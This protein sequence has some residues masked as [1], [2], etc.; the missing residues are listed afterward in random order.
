MRFLQT[1][2]ARLLCQQEIN[3]YKKK[4][5]YYI[6]FARK[7]QGKDLKAN[8]KQDLKND[9][10]CEIILLDRAECCQRFG[11]EDDTDNIKMMKAILAKVE[12]NSVVV[13]DETPLS[14][15]SETKRYSWRR[16]ENTRVDDDVFVIV[17]LQPIL[18]SSTDTMLSKECQIEGPASADVIELTNQYR[19]SKK[20][21]NLYN[22]LYGLPMEFAKVDCRPSHE[23]E[24]PDI[25][26]VH[27]TE[28]THMEELRTWMDHQID[29]LDCGTENLKVIYAEE[30]E[31]LLS[32]VFEDSKWENSFVTIDEF[33]GCETHSS[34][35]P[36]PPKIERAPQK[37]ASSENA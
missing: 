20:L 30:S 34:H 14:S 10:N 35:K 2:V 7:R 26:L 12:N 15:N 4:R 37:I 24:G 22:K 21:L 27:V 25:T 1:V 16:L 36:S 32:K 18:C 9:N 6:C 3:L 5:V 28:E 17:C 19:C 29:S 33:V 31:V 13:F 11:L 8:F 23:V